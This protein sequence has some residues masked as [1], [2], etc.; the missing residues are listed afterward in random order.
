MLSRLTHLLLAASVTLTGVI[1][2]P[3]CA[4]VESEAEAKC[5]C[6]APPVAARSCCTKPAVAARVCTCAANDEMPADTRV[7]QPRDPRASLALNGF[8]S[9]SDAVPG[10]S[11]PE[12]DRTSST[13]LSPA[14]RLH[15]AL[16]CWQI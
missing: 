5:C 10:H 15:A 2:E 3:S 1:R 11:A 8:A 12:V 6:A 13:Y 4:A 16:C 14:I 9:F 7:P